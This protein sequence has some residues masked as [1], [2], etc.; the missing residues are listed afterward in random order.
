MQSGVHATKNWKID[1]DTQDKWENRLMGKISQ[2]SLLI[3][4]MEY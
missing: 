1:F 3:I 4:N 2:I